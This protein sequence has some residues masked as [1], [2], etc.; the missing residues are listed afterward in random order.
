MPLVSRPVAYLGETMT[1]H[2]AFVFLSMMIFFIFMSLL[3]IS[4]LSHWISIA[5]I[6]ISI[7]LFIDN[8]E[9]LGL[10]KLLVVNRIF[11]SLSIIWFML[12]GICLL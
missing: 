3:S 1:K 5:G 12:L 9:C 10:K 4:Y 11:S 2:I 6:L 7:G 8:L